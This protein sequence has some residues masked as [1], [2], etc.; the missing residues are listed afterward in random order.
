MTPAQRER[1]W[2]ANVN[3]CHV[4]AEDGEKIAAAAAGAP[5]EVPLQMQ[6]RF[7]ELGVPEE[8]WMPGA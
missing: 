6:Q 4:W 1:A 3:T 8:Q 2:L 5:M 7:R